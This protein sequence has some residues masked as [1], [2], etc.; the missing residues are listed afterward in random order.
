MYMYMYMYGVLDMCDE[1]YTPTFIVFQVYSC[2]TKPLSN[3]I[4][5]HFNNFV[6]IKLFVVKKFS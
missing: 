4:F 3:F 2:S 1:I 5:I 6:F